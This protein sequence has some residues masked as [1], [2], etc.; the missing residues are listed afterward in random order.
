MSN[1]LG[2]KRVVV[3][4]SEDSLGGYPETIFGNRGKKKK[5]KKKQSK[6]LSPWEK[7]VRSL[8]KTQVKASRTYLDRHERSN[9]K[10]KNG[11]L[12]D[13]NKNA[14]KSLSKLGGAYSIYKLNLF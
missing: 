7:S 9:K 6:L 8:A 1:K 3:L 2:I 10:K 4:R 5:K 11:W 12:R 14:S 13:L